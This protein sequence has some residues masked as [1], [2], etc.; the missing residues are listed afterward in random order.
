MVRLLCTYLII[1]T[2]KDFG[3]KE[4]NGTKEEQKC[5]VTRTFANWLQ[6]F[7]FY[8]SVLGEKRSDLCSGLFQH[9][10]NVHEAYRHLGSLVWFHYDESYRQ[11]LAV[12]LN[13]K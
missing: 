5:P 11:K 7:S 2:E 12:Y 1:T 3:Q 13:I 10:D 9:L 4:R 8:V 6:A